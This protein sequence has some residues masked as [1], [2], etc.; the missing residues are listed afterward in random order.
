MRAL[1]HL[2]GES[3]KI[4]FRLGVCTRSGLKGLSSETGLPRWVVV[5]Y[6]PLSPPTEEQKSYYATKRT[7]KDSLVQ[8]IVFLENDNYSNLA[9]RTAYDPMSH[10]SGIGLDYDAVEALDSKQADT[11]LDVPVGLPYRE[12]YPLPENAI[13]VAPTK[14]SNIFNNH[15]ALPRPHGLDP[16]PKIYGHIYSFQTMCTALFEISR[17]AYTDPMKEIERVNTIKGMAGPEFLE[18]VR[19]YLMDGVQLSNPPPPTDPEVD[20]DVNHLLTFLLDV[21]ERSPNKAYCVSNAP[22]L[23]SFQSSHRYFVRLLGLN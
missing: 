7:A 13:G 4:S 21:F 10:W 9:T 2:F 15:R 14:H 23:G 20:V 18:H 6:D 1:V 16:D 3:I 17:M 19:G 11:S 8:I 5:I 12:K 22:Y